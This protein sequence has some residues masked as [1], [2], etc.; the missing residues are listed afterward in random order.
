LACL[1]GIAL[2][3]REREVL[4]ADFDINIEAIDETN[5]KCGSRI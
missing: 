3:C 5:G 4:G 1:Y 2:D